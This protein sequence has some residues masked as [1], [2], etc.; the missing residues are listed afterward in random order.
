MPTILRQ[1]EYKL[2]DKTITDVIRPVLIGTNVLQPYSVNESVLEIGWDEWKDMG[3]ATI[4]MYMEEA[5]YDNLVLKAR[6]TISVPII[7]QEFKLPWRLVQSARSG[8]RDLET[9]NIAAAASKVAE[10]A[11]ELIFKGDTSLKITGLTGVSGL[12][13]TGADFGTAGNAYETFRKVRDEFIGNNI[14]PPYVAVLNPTQYGELDLLF[15][16]TGIPQRERIVG[17]FVDKIYYSTQITAGEGYVFAS[18][19]QYMDRITLGGVKRK[20]WKENAGD[21][22]SNVLGRVYAIEVPR[23]RVAN[24]VLKVSAI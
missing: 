21:S 6:Q 8:G 15:S 23:V 19:K 2:I 11:E 17:N 10:K 18:S 5:N 14:Q 9:A 1:E 3:S 7:H 22:A 20:V 24:G 16:N 13:V 4:D 12:S